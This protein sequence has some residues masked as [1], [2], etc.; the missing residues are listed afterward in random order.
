MQRFAAAG[1][2][3]QTAVRTGAVSQDEVELKLCHRLPAVGEVAEQRA[4]QSF[5]QEHQAPGVGLRFVEVPAYAVR[6]WRHDR[7]QGSEA[8]APGHF[9]ERGSLGAEASGES[10]CRQGEQLTDGAHAEPLEIVAQPGDEDQPRQGDVAARGGFGLARTEQRDAAA[11]AGQ[12]IAAK[13]CESD[14]DTRGQSHPLQAAM[15]PFRPVER[16]A[17]KALEAVGVQPENSRLVPS[18][19]DLGAVAQQ[20]TL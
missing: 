12:A 20:M 4:E 2:V 9:V 17:V 19:F 5:D 15:Q 13:A 6:L 10:G 1:A 7:L 18:R 11:G 3:G 14:H 8:F 16:R